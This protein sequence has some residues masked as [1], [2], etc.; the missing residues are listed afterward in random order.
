MMNVTRWGA[1]AF[2]DSLAYGI[3]YCIYVENNKEN[4]IPPLE[5]QGSGS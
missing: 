4:T 5:S 2:T 3:H 1:I